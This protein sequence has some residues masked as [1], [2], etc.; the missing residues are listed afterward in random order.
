MRLPD[1]SERFCFPLVAN[2]C[3]DYM[4]KLKATNTKANGCTCCFAE[5]GQLDRFRQ[6][7]E[8]K[9]TPQMK[10]LYE[11][12]ISSHHPLRSNGEIVNKA[13]LKR[14]EKQLGHTRVLENAFWECRFFCP[15]CF[16]MPESLHLAD[17]GMFPHILFA[18]FKDIRAKVFQYVEDEESRWNEAMDRLSARL[19]GCTLLSNLGVGGKYVC[20]I[21]HKIT[22]AQEYDDSSPILKAWEFRLLMLVCGT[23]CAMLIKCFTSCAVSQHSS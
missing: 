15:Y 18:I 2:L 8:R 6:A 11:Q 19:E 22:E 13:A 17:L 12:F 21:G 1:G 23:P 16:S 5:K 9:T 10:Q 7:F 3:L 20:D 4:E 14:A